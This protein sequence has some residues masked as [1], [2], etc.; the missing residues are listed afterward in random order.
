MPFF[1]TCRSTES[2]ATARAG[3]QIASPVVPRLLTTEQLAALLGVHPRTVKR[4]VAERAV[5]GIVRP[6]GRMVRFDRVAVESWIARGCPRRHADMLA[7]GP[8]TE[9][10]TRPILTP[11][12]THAKQ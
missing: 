5:P 3:G 1:Q 11:P 9:T 7:R 4:M 12:E 8:W 6:Y 10:I 2:P